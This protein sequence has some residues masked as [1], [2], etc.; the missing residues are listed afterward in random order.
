M[1]F[2]FY[3]V[4]MWY[5]FFDQYKIKLHIDPS[6]HGQTT[7]VKQIALKFA[8]GCSV[9]KMRSYPSNIKGEF[10]NYY[11]NDIFFTWGRDSAKK[12]NKSQNKLDNII[13]SG[14]PYFQN[15]KKK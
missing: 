4:N 8:D 1:E 2:L 12:I 9:G 3:N 5:N 6:E 10:N 14:F 11:P 7:I 15:F 13:I